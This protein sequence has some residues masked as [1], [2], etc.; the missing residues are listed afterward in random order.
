MGFIVYHRK[1]KHKN[2]VL[3]ILYIEELNWGFGISSSYVHNSPLF[4][5]KFLWSFNINLQLN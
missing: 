4:K 3:M 2:V 1:K 5:S